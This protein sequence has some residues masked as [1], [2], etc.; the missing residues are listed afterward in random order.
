[1]PVRISIVFRIR[2]DLTIQSVDVFLDAA[3]ENALA[4]SVVVLL[5][6]EVMPRA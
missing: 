4:V 6:N 1:M 5:W 2:S 3:S